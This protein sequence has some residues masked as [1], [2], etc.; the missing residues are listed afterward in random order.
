MKAAGAPLRDIVRALL[1]QDATRLDIV[2]VVKRTENVD[3]RRARELTDATGLLP[4]DPGPLTVVVPQ[5]DPWYEALFGPGSPGEG[6]VPEVSSYEQVLSD[7]IGYARDDWLGVEVI[8]SAVRECFDHRPSF[9]EARPLAV[10]AVRDLV[11]EGA[12]AGDLVTADGSWRFEPWPVP[13]D[14]AIEW[15]AQSLDGRDSYPEP[16]AIGWLTFPR[17]PGLRDAPCDRGSGSN[18]GRGA[19]G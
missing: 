8:T 5:D 17:Q 16:G 9:A 4:P 6:G 15:I 1:D 2:R 14:Q 12:V 13:P 19:L 7:L 11:R 10:R 18:R 3:V